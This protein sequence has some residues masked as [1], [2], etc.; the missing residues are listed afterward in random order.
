M[1]VEPIPFTF[2]V[3]DAEIADLHDRLA[4]AFP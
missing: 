3:P 1:T 4:R 2:H